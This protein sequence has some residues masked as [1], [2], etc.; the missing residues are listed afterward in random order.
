DRPTVE[1]GVAALLADPRHGRYFVACD[2][3]RVVGQMMHTYEW[4]DWRNGQIWWLQSVYVAAD[5]RQRG[6]FRALFEHVLH[7]AEADPGVVGVRLYVEDENKSAQAAYAKLGLDE[8]G[9]HVMERMFA[10]RR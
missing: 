4:S 5:F 6:V 9:Y 1:R 10:P 2:G 7:A 3:P 8:A